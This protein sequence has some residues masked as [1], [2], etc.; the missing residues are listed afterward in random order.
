MIS[1][2]LFKCSFDQS[3]RL[4]YRSINAVFGPIGRMASEEVVIEIV[5]KKCLPILLY[6]TEA[7]PMNVSITKSFDF[8]INRFLMKLFRTNS[9]A[10]IDDCRFNFEI[11]FPSKLIDLRSQSSRVSFTGT[12]RL[13]IQFVERW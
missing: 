5:I 4:F 2:K 9:I 13:K 12:T 8:V 11:I 6:G 3:K 7:C 10:I 1:S